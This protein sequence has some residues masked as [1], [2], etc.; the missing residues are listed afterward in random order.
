M[1][2]LSFSPTLVPLYLVLLQLGVYKLN[3]H[4]LLPVVFP[5]G[6]ANWRYL[7]ATRRMVK[8]RFLVLTQKEAGDGSCYSSSGAVVILDSSSP[9]RTSNFLLV[10]TLVDI[11][12]LEQIQRQIHVSPTHLQQLKQVHRFQLRD[13]SCF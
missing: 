5:F 11:A 2:L 4:T 8:T 13:I 9:G 6:S 7:W 3:F 12:P 10:P 1:Y